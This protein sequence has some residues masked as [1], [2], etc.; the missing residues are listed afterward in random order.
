MFYN[1]E[2]TTTWKQLKGIYMYSSKQLGLSK[3]MYNIS[4]LRG[5][6][7]LFLSELHLSAPP[8]LLASKLDKLSI[9]P[10]MIH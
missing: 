5:S 4:M 3:S 6:K 9:T 10:C 2:V 8:N 1:R 7:F